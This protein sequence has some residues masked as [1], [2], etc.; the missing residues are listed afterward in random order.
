VTTTRVSLITP[1]GTEHD[2]TG[3]VDVT[4]APTR[5]TD[6]DTVIRTTTPTASYTVSFTMA[7]GSHDRLLA[8]FGLG[9]YL[10]RMHAAY[11]RKTARRNRRR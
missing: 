8:L 2:I 1:D 6:D 10:T 5:P 9:R 3:V 7:P 4:F 11:H